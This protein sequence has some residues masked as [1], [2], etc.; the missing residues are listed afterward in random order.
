MSFS[1]GMKLR[2]F[3]SNL[4]WSSTEDLAKF[5]VFLVIL[6]YSKHWFIKACI[7]NVLTAF[8]IDL[9]FSISLMYVGKSRGSRTLDKCN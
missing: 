3:V 2:N 5:E 9:Q 1:E 4:G 8:E 7:A 6:S